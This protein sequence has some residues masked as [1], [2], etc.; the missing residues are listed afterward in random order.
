M[1]VM[2]GIAPVVVQGD[3]G[4]PGDGIARFV[5]DARRGNHLLRRGE[6]PGVGGR[7]QGADGAR[8]LPASL[9]A[10]VDD[11]VRLY[12]AHHLNQLLGLPGVAFHVP[13]GEIEPHH[14]QLPIIR[15]KLLYLAEHVLQ[16]IVE[17]SVLVGI[18]RAVPHGMVHVPVMGEIRM[19]PVDHGVIQAHPDPLLPESLQE[20]PHQVPPAGGIGGLEVRQL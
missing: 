16:V 19:P 7:V 11:H 8:I 17:I 13:V 9:Q 2:G 6:V 10:V 15:Q 12:G 1:M 14:V 4:F 20:F 5:P 18:F 3:A